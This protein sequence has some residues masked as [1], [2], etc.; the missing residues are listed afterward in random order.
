MTLHRLLRES[1]KVFGHSAGEEVDFVVFL[2]L[3]LLL[4][5]AVQAN[6]QPP[7]KIETAGSWPPPVFRVLTSLLP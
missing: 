2:E 3:T 6:L 7:R 1:P 5:R 4:L